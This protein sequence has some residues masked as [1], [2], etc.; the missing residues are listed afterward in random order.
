MRVFRAIKRV[1]FAILLSV[2][3]M[4]CGMSKIEDQVE[5]GALESISLKGLTALELTFGLKNESK[6]RLEMSEGVIEVYI[7]GKHLM[8]LTQVGESVAEP[9]SEGSVETMWKIGGVDPLTMLAQS[10]RLAS[11]D[12]SGMTVDFS[13]KVKANGVGKTISGKG[14]ELTEFMTIFAK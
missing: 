11:R 10:K 9:R 13:A 8:Q 3:L 6:Y 12:F 2:A 14:V 1:A 7:E 5:V 4:S